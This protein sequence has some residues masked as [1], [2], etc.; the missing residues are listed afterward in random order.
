MQT[1]NHSEFSYQTETRNSCQHFEKL[2]LKSSR[3]SYYTWLSKLIT[4]IRISHS[5]S[6]LSQ[7]RIRM[8]QDFFSVR[9]NRTRFFFCEMRQN[10]IFILW[11]ETESNS[12]FMK[13]DETG[14]FFMRWDRTENESSFYEMRSNFCETEHLILIF[15]SV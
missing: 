12:Y 15:Q 1:E 4:R 8:R 5:D 9:W 6:V 7:V 3:L 2:Y 14:F 13:W 10:Q 11:D